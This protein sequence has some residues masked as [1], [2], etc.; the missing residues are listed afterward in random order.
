MKFIFRTVPTVLIDES[1]WSLSLPYKQAE[2]MLVFIR[3][4]LT[5]F[6]VFIHLPFVVELLRLYSRKQ[7]TEIL[8]FVWPSRNT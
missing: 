2:F 8:N 1:V 3:N 7:N 5:A 6:L 4:I